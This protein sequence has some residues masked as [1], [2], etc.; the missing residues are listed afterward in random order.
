MV[1]T[2]FFAIFG[3]AAVLAAIGVVAQRNVLYSGLLLV[4]NM[5]SLAALYILMNAQFLGV[6]QIIVYAG[7]VMVLFLFTVMLVGG[8]PRPAAPAKLRGQGWLAAALVLA[9]GVDLA[10]LLSGG[11]R[12]AVAPA[13]AAPEAAGNVQAVAEA[14]FGRY[15]W[16]FEATGLLLLVAV[17]GVVYLVRGGAAPAGQEATG[18]D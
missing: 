3:L 7:A 15:L 6:A 5:L 2:I 4:L 10:L 18:R 17:V 9:L 16:A 13:V 12:G 11:V 1:E 8:R 14:L